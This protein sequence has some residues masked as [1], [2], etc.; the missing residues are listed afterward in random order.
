MSALYVTDH[1]VV[2]FWDTHDPAQA[3]R[4]P[5]D[6]EVVCADCLATKLVLPLSHPGVHRLHIE[7]MD[8]TLLNVCRYC[9]DV[10]TNIARRIHALAM[11][12][13]KW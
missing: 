12:Q 10:D 8:E 6:V 11:E 3:R 1:S 5:N 13:F 2:R 9:G 4:R 7:E